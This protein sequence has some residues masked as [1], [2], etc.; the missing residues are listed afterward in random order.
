M[1]AF[2]FKFF[3]RF[4]FHSSKRNQLLKNLIAKKKPR[5]L[6]LGDHAKERVLMLLTKGDRKALGLHKLNNKK[7]YIKPKGL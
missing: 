1:K 4:C 7:K 2:F 6:Y 5:Y 3:S